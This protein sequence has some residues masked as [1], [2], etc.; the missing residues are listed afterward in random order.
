MASPLIYLDEDVYFGLARGLRRRGF[1]VLTTVEAGRMGTTD[2]EQL[3]F[4]ASNERAIF[5]FNRGDFVQLHTEFL[6]RGDSHYGIIVSR[7]LPVGTVVKGLCA[8]LS[9]YSQESLRN[10][11]LWLSTG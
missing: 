11:L 9:S 3:L 5:T 8:L 6:S 4:A 10:Q 2:E 1:D 7:Q